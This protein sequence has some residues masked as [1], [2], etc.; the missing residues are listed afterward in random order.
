MNRLYLIYLIYLLIKSINFQYCQYTQWIRCTIVIWVYFIYQYY[1]V[2]GEI[3]TKYIRYSIMLQ[4]Y[5][6][7]VWRQQLLLPGHLGSHGPHEDKELT[8]FPNL[9]EIP[10]RRT[11][12]EYYSSGLY[13]TLSLE[14]NCCT[15]RSNI[16]FW[17]PLVMCNYCF[18]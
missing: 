1:Q 9:Q 18:H 17:H 10:G 13:E 8:G 2:V 12:E 16:L 5:H 14:R 4:V 15:S 3:S 6:E 11:W 7:W